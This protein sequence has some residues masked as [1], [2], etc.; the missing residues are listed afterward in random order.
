ML[1]NIVQYSIVCLHVRSLNCEAFGLIC[2]EVIHFEVCSY[3]I[4]LVDT[5][6]CMIAFRL[7]L[8]CINVFLFMLTIYDFRPSLGLWKAYHGKVRAKNC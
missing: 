1:S 2:I 3:F 7:V 5:S 6:N 4:R 8:S